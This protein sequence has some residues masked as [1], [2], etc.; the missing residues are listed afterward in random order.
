MT[1]RLIPRE[2]ILTPD[3]IL[4]ILQSTVLNPVLTGSLLAALKNMPR[5]RIFQWSQTLR[6]DL[7][8]P[9]TIKTLKYLLIIGAARQANKVLSS[10]VVNNWERT[11]NWDWKNEVA[12]VTGGAGGIGYHVAVGLARRGITV[13]I[14]DVQEPR[15]AFRKFLITSQAK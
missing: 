5:E 7:L 4:S 3:F 11:T 8:S 10:L 13:A 15:A 2:G 9:T 6:I 14:V 12:L 1:P